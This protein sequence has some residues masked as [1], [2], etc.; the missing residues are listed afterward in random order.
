MPIDGVEI[1]PRIIDVGRRYF[2]MNEP[3]LNAVAADGR[4]F[5]D[6]TDQQ[7]DI[8]AID[9]YRQ[10]Y[11]PFQLTTKE[12]F[13]SCRKHLT[14]NGVVVVNVGRAP[15]DYRLVDAVSGTLL[16]VFPEVYQQDSAQF[17]NSIVFATNAR[18][19]LSEVAATLGASPRT[20]SS[21]GGGRPRRGCR[22]DPRRSRC[23]RTSRYTRTTWRRWSGLSTASSIAT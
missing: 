14:K 6:T 21:G 1:D 15:D 20:Y 9:A 5:L 17:L 16:A 7:Y 10:P 19:M 18:P 3:N 12:F 2:D 23:T 4:Y 22:A 8:I 13:Q 11:I